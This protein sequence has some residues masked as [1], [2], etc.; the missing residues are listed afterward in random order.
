M[1]ASELSQRLAREE[2]SARSSLEMARQQTLLNRLVIEEM[3]DGVLVVDRLGRVRAINPAARQLLGSTG[4]LMAVP[5][6]LVDE[7][8]LRPLHQALDRAYAEGSW[9]AS[10]REITLTLADGEHRV[11]QVRARFTRRS[12]IGADGTPPEDICVLFLEDMRTVQG[13]ARNDKLA[14]MGRVSAD[15]AHEI[16]NPLAA[17]A[18]ANAL[19]LEDE[20]PLQQQRLSRIVADNVDRLKRIVDDVLALAPGA[21]TSA[22]VIDATTEVALV[23]EEWRRNALPEAQPDVR[24]VLDLPAQAL[25]LRFDPEHLRRVLVNL[26]DNASRH[27]SD[28]AGAIRL[29]LHAGP[30]SGLVTL[31]VASDGVPIPPDV[32]RHLFEPFFSTRSRGTGL[33]LYICRELCERHGASIDFNLAPPSVQHRNVFKVV[34]REPDT[35][36]GPSMAPAA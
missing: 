19:L 4:A 6:P 3:A 26:L 21:V 1:L 27:A 30:A 12:G 10:A 11:L 20:L 15:I 29:G 8:C 23:C 32:E 2:R 28:E 16:R 14:A 24:L 17:I 13:R 25:L 35:G 22:A 36:H 31:S 34:M 5:S 7:P 18:Q 33:G 9:P